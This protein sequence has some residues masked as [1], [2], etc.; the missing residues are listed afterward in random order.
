MNKACEA[1]VGLQRT[2]NQEA[3]VGGDGRQQPAIS[4]GE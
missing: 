2:L 3:H 4:I 1:V